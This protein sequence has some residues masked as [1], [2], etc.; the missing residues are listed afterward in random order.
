MFH[1][2]LFTNSLFPFTC[3][4]VIQFFVIV[5]VAASFSYCFYLSPFEAE[6]IKNKKVEIKN[7]LLMPLFPFH[8]F[9]IRIGSTPLQ[10]QSTF[11]QD[12]SKAHH[13]IVT[14]W[15]ITAAKH[16]AFENHHWTVQ[17]VVVFPVW[18]TA[19][20][21]YCATRR[22]EKKKILNSYSSGIMILFNIISQF[23]PNV[24]CDV[25]F[26]F[27]SHFSAQVITKKWR[28][29]YKIKLSSKEAEPKKKNTQKARQRPSS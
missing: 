23:L 27:C 13:S 24:F 20:G 16:W 18:T 4:G 15:N 6:R 7:S 5:V 28:T 22:K 8:D 10:K 1:F 12:W 29:L 17:W 11:I 21:M 2:V 19:I 3:S 25:F 14:I 9:I 26:I